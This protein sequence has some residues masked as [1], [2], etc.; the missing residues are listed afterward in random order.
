LDRGYAGFA[1]GVRA[2]GIFSEKVFGIFRL[3]YAVFGKN[4]RG[5]SKNLT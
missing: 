5:G 4:R 3:I 2:P 1:V